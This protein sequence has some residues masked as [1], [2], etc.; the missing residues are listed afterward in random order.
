MMHR[1][2]DNLT[3]IDQ[4][5]ELAESYVVDFKGNSFHIT[6]VGSYNPKWLVASFVLERGLRD[7]WWDIKTDD[8][9]I[10]VG[11]AFG[12]YTLSALAA[13]AA[14]VVA[15]EPSKSEYFDLC[16]N[17]LANGY[18]QRCLAITCLLGSCNKVVDDYYHASHSHRPEGARESRMQLSLDYIVDSLNKVDWIKI[19][20]EGDELNVLQG[21]LGTLD[22]Y[23]PRLLIENHVGIVPGV[24]EKIR[25]LL[26]P[27]GYSEEN[28]TNPPNVNDNWSRWTWGGK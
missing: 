28:R 2:E 24:D 7:D 12:S 5:K 17:I 11:A 10:D 6:T 14:F 16:T 27:M 26:I 20:V 13:G 9:V 19:D 25:E 23:H 18:V 21:A 1:T 8:V 15:A 22:K 3:T 4:T